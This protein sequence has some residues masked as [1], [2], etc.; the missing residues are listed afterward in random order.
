MDKKPGKKAKPTKKEE[1]RI[2]SM[3]NILAC[4]LDL[5]VKNGFRATTIDL[6]AAK[7]KLTKGAVY[8]YFKTKDAIL[9][10]LLDE[11]ER[12][13]VDPIAGHIAEAGPG[14]DAKLVKFI[15]SQ[16]V[17]GVTRPKHVLLLIL[18]SIE[19]SGSGTEIETRVKAIYRRMYAEIKRIIELGQR[20]GIFRSDI[21]SLDLTAIVM[22]GHD[23]VMVEWYRRPRELSG[24]SL[25]NALRGTILNGLVKH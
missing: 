5:C 8:F 6:I 25:A 10:H 20:E 17:L 24:K 12:F 14:A 18:V 22:A 4:A 16:S 11:A 23:G 2:A 7:A 9:L 1:Q 3:E 19:F 15:N 13:I 21:A